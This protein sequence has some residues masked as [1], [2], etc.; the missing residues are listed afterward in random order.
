[1]KVSIQTLA[2][3][4]D[5]ATMT[6]PV[7]LLMGAKDQIVCNEKSRQFIEQCGAPIKKEIIY[8]D[9]DH[10]CFHEKDII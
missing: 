9:Q 6:T 5:P 7:L 8:E 10:M 1:M 4:G 3:M 2:T